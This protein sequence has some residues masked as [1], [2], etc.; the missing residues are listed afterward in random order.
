MSEFKPRSDFDISGKIHTTANFGCLSRP[1]HA[2][3]SDHGLL[4][5]LTNAD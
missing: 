2:S 5:D 4:L 1:D 3:L